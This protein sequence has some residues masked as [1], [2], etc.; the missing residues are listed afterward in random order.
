MS[1]LCLVT[2]ANG[3]LG[4]NLVRELVGEGKRVRASVRRVSDTLPFKEV[5]CEIVSADMLDRASLRRA[6]EH[7]DVVYHCAAVFRHW[8]KYPISEIVKTNLD[9]TQNILEAAAGMDV[10]K[11][12]YVSSIVALDKSRAPMNELGW[13]TDF[14]SPYHHA[15]TVSERMALELADKLDLWLVSVLPAAMIGPHAYGRLTP[16]MG[17]VNSIISNDMR[18]DIGFVQNLVDVRDVVAGMISAA[19]NGRKGNRYILGN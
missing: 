17:L 1:E 11:I 9:G 6:F 8:A 14:S 16:A 4:N 5:G 13:N 19:K 2:G 10:K 7:V 12:V 15:K 18:V 3:H